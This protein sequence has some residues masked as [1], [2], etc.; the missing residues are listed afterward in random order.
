MDRK[1]IYHTLR[2]C[3][4]P[5]G[6]A[7]AEYIR[8]HRIFASVGEHCDFMPRKIPLYP[9][10]IKIGSHV[11]IST[12][13]SFVTHDVIHMI[14]DPEKLENA[15]KSIK[16]YKFREAVGC[17]EIGDNVFISTG[18]VI[19]Y[20]VKI[21]NNVIITAGSV[22]SQDVPSNSVVRGN[23]A[24]V[25]CGFNEFLL[26]KASKDRYPKDGFRKIGKMDSSLN[27]WL[28]DDFYGRRSGA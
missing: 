7:R 8:K 28:W 10:L 19:L 16:N 15:R 26:M 11:N 20:D 25:I 21:G 24:K 1:R 14:I 9:N 3:M 4:I 12:N 6:G 13:V 17:I 2:L 22:V 23:P 5:S 27:E 18:S